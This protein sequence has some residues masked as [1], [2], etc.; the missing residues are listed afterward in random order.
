ML[1]PVCGKRTCSGLSARWK[2]A[3]QRT[4]RFHSI[5]STR[6]ELCSPAPSGRAAVTVKSGRAPGVIER[7][8]QR[9]LHGRGVLALQMHFDLRFLNFLICVEMFVA[10]VAYR[11]IYR[12]DGLL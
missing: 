1:P 3:R 10:A 2:C 7:L 9:R 5:C 8:R 4:A 6:G 12:S 11:S